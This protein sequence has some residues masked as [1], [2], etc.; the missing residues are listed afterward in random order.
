ME[1]GQN[2]LNFRVIMS[3]ICIATCNTANQMEH[4]ASG[5]VMVSSQSLVATL[6]HSSD[7]SDSTDSQ[8]IPDS[9]M[10]PSPIGPVLSNSQEAT[11]HKLSFTR[12][13]SQNSEHNLKT[14]IEGNFLK[15]Y[16]IKTRQ[17][18]ETI[19]SKVPIIRFLLDSRS[20]D[21]NFR[22][23]F[24]SRKLRI[25]QSRLR[26]RREIPPAE[27]PIGIPVTKSGR[28]TTESHTEKST[29]SERAATSTSSNDLKVTG[30]TDKV[31]NRE[32]P[33]LVD[34]KLKS[35]VPVSGQNPEVPEKIL[36]LEDPNNMTTLMNS[37]VQVTTV[38]PVKQGTS[39][40][41][42]KALTT[43]SVQV[44]SEV[45]EDQEVVPQTSIS[46]KQTSSKQEPNPPTTQPP[47]T[48][49]PPI[50]TTTSTVPKSSKTTVPMTTNNTLLLIANDTSIGSQVEDIQERMSDNELDSALLQTTDAYWALGSLTT[51]LLLL[52]AAVLFTG[53]WKKRN[54]MSNPIS[55][56]TCH[57][58]PERKRKTDLK[59][60][61]KKKLRH[62]K[63]L[64][65]KDSPLTGS[66]EMKKYYNGRCHG[67]SNGAYSHRYDTVPLLVGPDDE[68]EDEFIEWEQCEKDHSV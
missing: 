16:W 61:L 43:T 66:M 8:H 53:L 2:W 12:S 56:V 19:K 17:L 34:T 11:V 32:V 46:P 23:N 36:E 1:R 49:P 37:S 31:L 5:F 28:T 4:D 47:Q 65:L 10:K 60:F 27:N 54:H 42:T 51:V 63:T 7:N 22:N 67:R 15:N 68:E 52:T 24:Q 3:F 45:T 50:V 6:D 18:I 33:K 58:S 9:N 38:S 55:D 64:N 41:G 57:P 62:I 20:E 39:Q 26:L 48:K 14:S 13:S 44:T 35:T 40:S 29:T 30:K 21:D 59:D 25:G